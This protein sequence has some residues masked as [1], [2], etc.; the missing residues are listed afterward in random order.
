MTLALFGAACADG[1]SEP[2]V[3]TFTLQVQVAYPATY[4]TRGADGARVIL[5]STERGSADTTTSSAGGLATFENVIPG[6][7]TVSASRD[8][9]A[10]DAERLTGV[11]QPLTLN[12][13]LPASSFLER[14]PT[15][16]TLTLA[17]SRLG[18][19]VIK[20]VYF[21]GS[22]TPSGG[23]YFSD[24]FT[25]LYN[26]STDTIYLDGVLIADVFG[27]SGQ[28]NPANVP[29]PFQSDPDNVYVTSI[30]QIPGTGQQRPLA[31]GQ[32]VIIAQDG[33]NHRTDPNGNPNSP[34]DLATADWETYNE[35]P[36]GRDLDSPTVPNLTR[37]VHR[38]GFDWLQT[39]F[40]P[41]VVVFRT[42]NVAAL[43]TV[44]V[45]GTTATYR[46]RVPNAAVIDA[47][48]ALQNGNAGA[49]K[50]LPAALD[51]GFVFASGTY[52]SESARRRTA[53]VIG[54]RRVLQDTNNSANDFVITAPGP[55]RFD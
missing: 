10:T 19:L 30:W 2:V 3:E 52:T 49:Y 54:T 51:A 43:D 25:E 21:T 16:P 24:Q 20:E 36:D 29:T 46:T 53:R 40:G 37:I 50:R 33:I 38:G 44:L 6:T 28:I 27:V 7:Y 23:T 14:P 41:G 11:A 55:R 45:P 48:E 42:E 9:S 39:V 18:D 22:S 26:N 13:L 17:G 32:S 34:V 47:F 12:A 5:T 35:R 31:P 8:L 15:L 1:A 4:D